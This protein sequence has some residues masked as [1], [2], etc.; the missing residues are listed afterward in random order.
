[1]VLSSSFFVA[2]NKGQG[3]ANAAATDRAHPLPFLFSPA[4]PAATQAPQSQTVP[5]WR[6]LPPALACL[7]LFFPLAPAHSVCVYVCV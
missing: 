7:A 4:E 1:M 3:N 2:G 5:A 6:V